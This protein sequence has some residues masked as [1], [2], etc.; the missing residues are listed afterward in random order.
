MAFTQD[1]QELI[2]QV[3]DLLAQHFGEDVE[4]VLHD[5]THDYEHTIVDIR[6]GLPM[7]WKRAQT[8]T[9]SVRI[10]TARCRRWRKVFSAA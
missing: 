3:F 6:N 2:R 9:S 4:L 10:L 1:N 5:Y 7:N 8:A